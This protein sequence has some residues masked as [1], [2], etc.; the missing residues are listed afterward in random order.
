[1]F[2]DWIETVWSRTDTLH[3]LAAERR[4][5]PH[6]VLRGIGSRLETPADGLG[7]NQAFRRP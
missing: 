4:Q 6:A 3:R 5:T 7:L 2:P 1:M